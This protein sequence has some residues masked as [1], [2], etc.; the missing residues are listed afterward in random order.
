[1][2]TVPEPLNDAMRLRFNRSAAKPFTLSHG[3]AHLA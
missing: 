1:L 2:A 3:S